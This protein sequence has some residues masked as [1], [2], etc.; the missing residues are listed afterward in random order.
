MSLS[1]LCACFMENAWTLAGVR[2]V[3]LLDRG[4]HLRQ[5]GDSRL[6]ACL[7]IP[8]L[9]DVAPTSPAPSA[10]VSMEAS[11]VQENSVLLEART[12]PAALVQRT[13]AVL[14]TANDTQPCLPQFSIWP[15]LAPT[16]PLHV[17]TTCKVQS[18]VQDDA[19]WVAQLAVPAYIAV[20]TPPLLKRL[21][22]I[23]ALHAS[24]LGGAEK[25]NHK[26]HETDHGPWSSMFAAPSQSQI[27]TA[28]DFNFSV[29]TPFTF[30]SFS[31]PCSVFCAALIKWNLTQQCNMSCCH[32][33][34]SAAAHACWLIDDDV[35]TTNESCLK[36]LPS[37]IMSHCPLYHGSACGTGV[38]SSHLLRAPG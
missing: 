22:R 14:S 12:M 19:P 10:C 34:P 32:V 17:T 29:R 36:N 25:S 27:Q 35:P 9:L 23:C 2:V 33:C 37:L 38:C 20:V 11:A 3:E 15:V 7:R 4:L 13:G 6:R 21:T 26:N 28:H 31:C 1:A 30:V 8:Q 5:G 16:I 24:L 18:S